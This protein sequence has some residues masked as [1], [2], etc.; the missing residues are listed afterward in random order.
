MVSPDSL[1]AQQFPIA[2]PAGMETAG[3]HF[4]VEPNRN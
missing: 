4:N 1:A 3:A 2:I